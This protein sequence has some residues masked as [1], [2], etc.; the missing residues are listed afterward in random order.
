MENLFCEAK[1]KMNEKQ[2]IYDKL[3]AV[4]TNYESKNATENDLY[5]ILVEI[6][7]QWEVVITANL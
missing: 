7:N 3:S 4:L 6:Q 5:E 1:N 2:I